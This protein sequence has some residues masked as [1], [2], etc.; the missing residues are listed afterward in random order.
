[1]AGETRGD[2]TP[3]PGVVQLRGQRVKMVV[4]KANGPA[5]QI[6]LQAP[7]VPQELRAGFAI[8][9][10]R[11]EVMLIVERQR[12]HEAGRTVA[13]CRAEAVFSPDGRRPIE[14]FLTARLGHP[15]PSHL[16]YKYDER[17]VFFA[18]DRSAL[19][20][21]APAQPE[22]R[23]KTTRVMSRPLVREEEVAIAEAE[24]EQSDVVEVPMPEVTPP[25]EPEPE[26]TP[27][28]AAGGTEKRYES[29][30]QTARVVDA[31]AGKEPLFAALSE[32]SAG[33][34]RMETMEPP[35]IDSEIAFDIKLPVGR[36]E[37]NVRA[38][39]KVVWIESGEGMQLMGVSLTRIDDGA[40]GRHWRRFVDEEAERG[41]LVPSGRRGTPLAAA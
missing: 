13:R 15:T 22:G 31:Y 7:S 40:A 29:R 17:G 24:L 23:K 32:V 21:P 5:L 3:F 28:P 20:Q 37:F 14:R 12:P 11:V 26:P 10:Q 35:P 16:N 41:V 18:F 2:R 33:G 38:F 36:L 9:D 30:V 25:P 8:D 39:G 6:V 27:E 4:V 34:V 19:E 1:M